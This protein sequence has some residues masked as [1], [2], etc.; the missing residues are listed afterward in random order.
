MVRWLPFVVAALFSLAMASAAPDGRRPFEFDWQLS[1]A[2]LSFSLVKA[3]HITAC[4]AL[5]FLALLAAGRERWG[6]AMLVTLLVGLGWELA[7]TT[8]VGRG[9]RL[10]DLDPDALG[11]ALGCGLAAVSLWTIELRPT[12]STRSR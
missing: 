6:Q 10:S 9:A 5:G 4:A 11:A 8:V 7:Q 3:N 12:P 1:A 2:A